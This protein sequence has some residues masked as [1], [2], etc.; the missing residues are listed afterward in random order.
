M[1]LQVFALPCRVGASLGGLSEER[2]ASLEAYGRALSVAFELMEQV[3]ELDGTPRR[4]GASARSDL[5][6]GLLGV[7]LLHAADDPDAAPALERLLSRRP[8]SSGDVEAVRELIRTTRARE[9]TVQVAQRFA[10]RARR[11]LQ[12]LSQQDATIAL[13]GLVDFTLAQTPRLGT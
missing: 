5:A 1:G 8:L 4:L 9:S 2:V 11:E 3:H 10:A 13:E 6:D 12:K 7:P